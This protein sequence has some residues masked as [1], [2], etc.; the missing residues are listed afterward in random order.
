MELPSP[1]F[2]ITYKPIPALRYLELLTSNF[3]L[4]SFFQYRKSFVNVQ[5]VAEPE[6]FE[7]LDNNS[8]V[9]V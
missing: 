1:G 4:T 5:R 3:S 8:I 9:Y 2:C 6:K 7:N